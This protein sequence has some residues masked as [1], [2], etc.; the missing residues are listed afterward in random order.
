MLSLLL[1]T[2]FLLIEGS[3]YKSASGPG[4]TYNV[5]FLTTE[6][7]ADGAVCLDG[8]PSAYYYNEGA[9]TSK[10]YIHQEGGGWCGS[11]EDCLSRSKGDLGSSKAY[12]K[13]RVFNTGYFSSD[14]LINPL[15]HNFSKIYLPYCDGGSQTGDLTLP[16]NVKSSTI[17]Y[18]GHRILR[19]MIPALMNRMLKGAT[20]VVIS[21]CSA[22]GLSTYLHAD[23][24]G[25]ALPGTK[26]VALP[27]S[28]FFLDYNSSAN[29]YSSSMRWVFDAMNSTGGV[30]A[31]CRAANPSDPA[32][33]IFAE[34]V[35]PTL[36]VPFFPMQSQYDSWQIGND[37]RNKDQ[38]AINA[39]GLKLRGLVE[40]N[41][42][43]TNTHNGVFLDA[44]YHHCGDWGIT[45]DGDS[46]AVAFQTWY[47]SLGTAGAKQEW[48]NRSSYPC[49]SC[50]T[51]APTDK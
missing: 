3:P 22:G 12:P 13:T 51:I 42:L 33:C 38:A 43:A 47:N 31:A 7:V 4:D 32:L 6:A 45:I 10:F 9:E 44:C 2:H 24:W 5:T 50:C 1:Y 48:V 46:T 17:Y 21:G 27:D 49:A 20:D 36:K 26:V 19:A 30:P 37:L 23:E 15:M 16:V 18:R 41:L 35:A 8:S 11:D 34:H 39:Y 14:P 29:G 28:G 25:A 40:K